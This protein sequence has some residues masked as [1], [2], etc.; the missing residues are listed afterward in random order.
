MIDIDI[1]VLKVI[2]LGNRD[3]VSSRLG[4]IRVGTCDVAKFMND[5]VDIQDRCQRF[6][7]AI[8][9]MKMGWIDNGH[10]HGGWSGIDASD[11]FR[12]VIIEFDLILLVMRR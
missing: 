3:D 8:T 11:V 5:L 2:H 10:Y 7:F 12:P 9:I 1:I 4:V 6:I